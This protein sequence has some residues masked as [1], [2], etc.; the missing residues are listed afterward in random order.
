MRL[1]S[2][3]FAV[4][5]LF[6]VS[7]AAVGCGGQ[8]TDES[9]DVAVESA[10][11]KTPCTKLCIIGYHLNNSCQCVADHQSKKITCGS[12]TCNAGEYCCNASCGICAPMGAM[13]IQAVCATPL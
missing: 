10:A 4:F 6:S 2:I 11:L 12:N 7:V 5:A 9:E 1:Q 8:P 3:L 13:C